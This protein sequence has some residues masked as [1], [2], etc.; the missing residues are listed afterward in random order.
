[1]E[2]APEGPKAIPL[3]INGRAFLTASQSFYVLTD[4]QSGEALWRVPLTGAAEAAEA[5]AAARAAQSAWAAMGM[6]ARR[7][8]L[9]GL[10]KALDRY[11][12]H[13]AKLLI[14]ECGIEQTQAVAEVERAVQGLDDAGVGATGVCGLVLDANRPL[15][16]FVAAATPALLAGATLV[17]KP[18]VKAPSAVLALC[19]LASRTDWPAG[20]LNVIHG[21]TA[22]IEGLC[23][24]ELDRLVYAGDCVLGEKIRDIAAA[25]EM[26]FEMH[27]V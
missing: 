27:A 26:P 22:A 20:V 7:V 25:V 8:C 2:F 21:D 18:S 10:A 3:W 6:V 1:M 13:F 4:P 15:A 12:G 24:A 16:A 19:E 5:V 17:V 14:Q 11:T 9:S 23:A